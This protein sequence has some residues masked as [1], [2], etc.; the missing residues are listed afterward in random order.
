MTRQGCRAWVRMYTL[1]RARGAAAHC[2]VCAPDSRQLAGAGGRLR[3]GVCLGRLH[4]CPP[5]RHSQ[6]SGQFFLRRGADDVTGKLVHACE[7]RRAGHHCRIVSAGDANRGRRGACINGS[8]LVHHRARIV[9][10]SNAQSSR[11]Y[12]LT[13]SSP[14]LIRRS[15]WRGSPCAHGAHPRVRRPR[16]RIA[17]GAG[18]GAKSSVRSS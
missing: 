11:H 4:D 18:H 13:P 10:R 12:V 16:A 14:S 9:P 6:S 8:G 5:P 2:G 1:A 7:P 3:M 15:V 17:N